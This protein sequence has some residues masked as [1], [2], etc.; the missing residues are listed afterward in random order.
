MTFA[1][2]M[3]TIFIL[4]KIIFVGSLILSAWICVFI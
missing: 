3:A 4:K 2:S 1:E